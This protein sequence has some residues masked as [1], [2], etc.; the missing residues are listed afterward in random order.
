MQTSNS[1]QSDL[2]PSEFSLGPVLSVLKEELS[3]AGFAALKGLGKHLE[4]LMEG[5]KKKDEIRLHYFR[6]RAKTSGKEAFEFCLQ[7]YDLEPDLLNKIIY[8]RIG[9]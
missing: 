3:P 6:L 7:E 2:F 8:P 5:Q 9:A 1:V 4:H